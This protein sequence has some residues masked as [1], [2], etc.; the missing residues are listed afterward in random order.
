MEHQ[1]GLPVHL[2]VFD[3]DVRRRD[4]GAVHQVIQAVPELF[5]SSPSSPVTVSSSGLLPKTMM[6]PSPVA[7]AATV[8][9]IPRF[10][11]A[12]AGSWRLYSSCGPPPPPGAPP[13]WP[14]D[15]TEQRY[16]PRH[17]PDHLSIPTRIDRA[18]VQPPSAVLKP[19]PG[20]LG[21]PSVQGERH[22]PWAADRL[23]GTAGHPEQ[24]KLAA[25]QAGTVHLGGESRRGH[26]DT[27]EP[28]SILDHAQRGQ[29]GGRALRAGQREIT[30]KNARHALSGSGNDGHD[31]PTTT[32]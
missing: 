5:G 3:C 22:F 32:Y 9:N 12:S 1:D 27:A 17:A 19:Q 6:P 2:V 26:M 28:A 18:I 31:S 21:Q 24:L 7:N 23:R 13:R 25:V 15:R 8:L 14:A 20:M 10:C 29:I 11:P 4:H 30:L 16:P